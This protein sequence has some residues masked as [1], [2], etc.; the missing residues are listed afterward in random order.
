MPSLLFIVKGRLNNLLLFFVPLLLFWRSSP[1]VKD[2][3]FFN[4][5]SWKHANILLKVLDLYSRCVAQQGQLYIAWK[6]QINQVV[7]DAEFGLLYIFSRAE[8]CHISHDQ[9]KLSTYKPPRI[10]TRLP[11]G[12]SRAPSSHAL[13]PDLCCSSTSK[14]GELRLHIFVVI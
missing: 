6:R 9:G 4:W 3:S 2:I 14:V 5:N 1:S 11:G 12:N 10:F 7:N 13:Q 8:H